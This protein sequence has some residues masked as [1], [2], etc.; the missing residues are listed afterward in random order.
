LSVRGLV[1]LKNWASD[2]FL[3]VVSAEGGGNVVRWWAL[4][5]ACRDFF[6]NS[7]IFS[8]TNSFGPLTSNSL[9]PT[10]TRIV[11]ADLLSL[12]ISQSSSQLIRAIFSVLFTLPPEYES[13]RDVQGRIFTFAIVLI[14]DNRL[15]A[16][17]REYNVNRDV[18]GN[19][20]TIQNTRG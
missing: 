18:L 15:S 8:S 14:Y 13:S 5:I 4:T 7:S 2:I 9:S 12:A 11:T 6:K 16:R 1:F 19:T 17:Q 3:T 10:L 20:A